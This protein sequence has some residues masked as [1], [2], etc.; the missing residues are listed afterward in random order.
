MQVRAIT[1]LTKNQNGFGWVL[2]DLWGKGGHLNLMRFFKSACQTVRFDIVQN[3]GYSVPGNSGPE[4]LLHYRG[5]E[6][7]SRLMR[8]AQF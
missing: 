4:E 3:F 2:G 7:C 6:L 5:I 1:T 8:T